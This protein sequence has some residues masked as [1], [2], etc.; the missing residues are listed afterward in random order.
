MIKRNLGATTK[1]S[2]ELTRPDHSSGNILKVPNINFTIS[3]RIIRPPERTIKN[4]L[5][6]YIPP[7]D[8]KYSMFPT[9]ILQLDPDPINI[10]TIHTDRLLLVQLTTFLYIQTGT[11]SYTHLTL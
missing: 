7:I 9:I 5:G 1:S 10:T 6:G 3:E 2:Q 4:G 11:V 8:R